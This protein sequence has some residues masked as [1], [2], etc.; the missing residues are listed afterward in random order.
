MVSGNVNVYGGLI[1]YFGSSEH[2]IDVYTLR[3][4]LVH[5]VRVG[6]VEGKE[7]ELVLNSEANRRKLGVMI[8]KSFPKLFF[9]EI[10][11]ASCTDYHNMRAHKTTNPLQRKGESQW[12]VRF[13]LGIKEPCVRSCLTV[14]LNRIPGDKRHRDRR[15]RDR[16][17]LLN[18]GPNP[19]L[20][21]CVG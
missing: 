4:D 16:R 14:G 2:R 3:Q 10:H 20:A 17:A 6:I 11:K 5:P 19:N 9:G 21:P 13:D 15:H 1:A 8:P 18:P 7:L 12:L